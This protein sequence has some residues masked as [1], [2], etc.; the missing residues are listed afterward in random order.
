MTNESER[1]KHDFLHPCPNCE[2]VETILN[3]NEDGLL[4]GELVCLDCGIY[5]TEE[6]GET[7]TQ[8]E[9]EILQAKLEALEARFEAA[10]GRGVELADEIDELRKELGLY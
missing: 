6:I 3:E 2:G 4:T 9:R 10:G 5:F 8:E 1:D 7:L